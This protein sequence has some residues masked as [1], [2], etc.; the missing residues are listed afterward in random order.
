MM[1]PAI[2]I[3][4]PRLGGHHLSWLRYLSED[5]L[6]AGFTVSLAVDLRPGKRELIEGH[7]AD[8]LPEVR[9]YSAYDPNGHYRAGGKTSSL[10][11]CFAESLAEQIFLPNFDE[12]AS[13]WLRRAAFGWCPPKAFRG[14]LNA[15]YFRPRFL[16]DRGWPPGNLVK[17]WGF[18]R[19]CRQGWFNNLYLLDEYLVDKVKGVRVSRLPDPFSG[20]YGRDK[21]LA[22]QRLGLPAEAFVFLHYGLGTRRKG[23]HLVH[24]AMR[25]PGMEGVFLLQAGVV[26]DDQDLLRG[27]A[28]LAAQGRALVLNRYVTQ[29]EEELCFAAADIV[30]LPY[31]GHFG[32]SA[33]LSRAAA[34]GK[35]VIVSDDALLGRRVRDHRLGLLVEPGKE[36]SLATAMTGAMG[37]GPDE[38]ER[39]RQ[40]A[41]NYAAGCTRQAFREVIVNSLSVG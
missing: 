31:C 4:E 14:R 21:S 34:S 35:A 32:S 23:L 9:V 10:S 25:Q 15:I 38:R 22:R 8:L 19:L 5:L 7:L 6:A 39:Y 36:S 33:V 17:A 24:A 37:F 1:R 2:F 30:L 18:N 20:E 27:S 28:E 11:R 29:E 41:L 16:A 13:S 26:A 40:A 12:V 3:F